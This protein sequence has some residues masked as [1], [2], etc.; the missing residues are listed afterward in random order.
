MIMDASQKL[1]Q[2]EQLVNAL[3]DTVDVRMGC[4]LDNERR[5]IGYQTAQALRDLNWFVRPV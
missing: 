4:V 5:V 2:L 3:L 1:E